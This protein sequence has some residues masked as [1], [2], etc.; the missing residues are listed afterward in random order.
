LLAHRDTSEAAVPRCP[1]L[2]DRITGACGSVE[3]RAGHVLISRCLPS[4][5]SAGRSARSGGAHPHLRA[6]R[7]QPHRQSHQWFVTASPIG[8]QQHPHV[9]P[10][11]LRPFLARPPILQHDPGLAAS[12]PVC[13][14]L[15]VARSEVSLPFAFVVRPRP[16]TC[17]GSAGRGMGPRRRR[18]LPGPQHRRDGHR[19]RS[20]QHRERTPAGA[21]G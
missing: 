13:Y 5:E 14:T 6:Q 15:K 21:I 9:V 17:A 4:D 18:A 20:A 10:P 3:P 8:R 16:R 19:Q 7:P 2:A 11:C 1:A 12:P